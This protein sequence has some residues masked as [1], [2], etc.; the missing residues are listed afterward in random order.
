MFFLQQSGW[1]SGQALA[2]AREFEKK[3]KERIN[4]RR[5]HHPE[6]DP[7]CARWWTVSI[8]PKYPH[9]QREQHW[10]QGEEGP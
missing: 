5:V 8:Y 4:V 6:V 10:E 3:K 1:D 2:R 7:D 9:H